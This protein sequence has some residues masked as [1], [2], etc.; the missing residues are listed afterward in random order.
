MKKIGTPE[1]YVVSFL[2]IEGYSASV[3]ADNPEETERLFD[4][5]SKMIDDAMRSTG[6]L[7]KKA[8]R[9]YGKRRSVVAR[10]LGYRGFSDNIV[11]FCGLY[12]DPKN[13]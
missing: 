10:T 8:R 13:K 3:T 2:D 1:Q 11:V 7:V 4:A 9:K 6:T 12:P 5:V